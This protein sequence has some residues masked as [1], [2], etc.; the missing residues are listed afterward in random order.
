M[1]SQSPMNYAKARTLH[2]DKHKNYFDNLQHEMQQRR[3][4]ITSKPTVPK[5]TERGNINHEP[6]R[7]TT[8]PANFHTQS[9]NHQSTM[10]RDK[11]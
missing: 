5:Y 4:K 9:L 7:K 2:D 11:I 1:S 3:T 10:L 6:P 8:D